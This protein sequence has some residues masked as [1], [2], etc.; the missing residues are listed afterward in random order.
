MR[1]LP[2]ILK[3]FMKPKAEEYEL[4]DEEQLVSQLEEMIRLKE[5]VPSDGAAD[6]KP[7]QEVKAGQ[8]DLAEA[9]EQEGRRRTAAA[10][11]RRCLWRKHRQ[12]N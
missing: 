6:E 8:P 4:P 12:M 3:Y 9:Q 5:S 1:S 7:V 2:S 11:S 10:L